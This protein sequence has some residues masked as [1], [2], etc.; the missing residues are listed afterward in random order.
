MNL[1]IIHHEKNDIW[2]NNYFQL[3]SDLSAKYHVEDFG[4]VRGK[5]IYKGP[6]VLDFDSVKFG[7]QNSYTVSSSASVNPNSY[8]YSG[9]LAGIFNNHLYFV[10]GAVGKF[11]FEFL[12][13]QN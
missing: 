3:A 6:C 7:Y 9:K 2:K 11:Y 5:Y 8:F 13:V 10:K 12:N 1:K 4:C